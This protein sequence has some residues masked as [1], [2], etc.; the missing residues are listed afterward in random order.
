MEKQMPRS[1]PTTL[2]SRT[3]SW[4]T[5]KHTS[6][7][8]RVKE[9]FQRDWAQTRADFSDKEPDL[10][11]NVGDTV[12][13]ALGSEPIPPPGVKTRPDNPKVVSDARDDLLDAAREAREKEAKLSAAVVEQRQKLNEKVAD[14]QQ[15]QARDQ[16]KAREKIQ[17]AQQSAAEDLQKQAEKVAKAANKRDEAA[18]AWRY[19][20]QEA[21]YGYAVHAQRPGETWN[22][23][24]ERALRDEWNS[25]GMGRSW[26]DA[27][28]GIRS[29]W[30]YADRKS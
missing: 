2:T 25:L 29:G 24:L 6:A 10:N 27:R 1:A 3:P 8:D 11:Q 5:D 18:A 17:D 9:A 30:D 23:T 28:A 7:W 19:A 21:R 14:I 22:D 4:W 20:E 12:K 16:M 13:Q 26:E 15:D